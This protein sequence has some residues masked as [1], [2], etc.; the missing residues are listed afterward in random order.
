MPSFGPT[1]S[2]N[3]SPTVWCSGWTA[4]STRNSC[5]AP[6]RDRMTRRSSGRRGCGP[7]W[8]RARPARRRAQPGDRA[9]DVRRRS[10]RRTMP[11][12]TAATK[13]PLPSPAAVPACIIRRMAAIRHARTPVLDIAYEEAGPPDGPPV[14]LLHGFPY[15][16]RAYD[17]VVPILAAAGR[18]CVVPYLR[19]YGPTRFLSADTPRSGEQAALGQD[20]LDLLDALAHPARGA[21]RLRLGRARGLRGGRPLAGAL[22]RPGHLH[23]LQHPGHRR[24]RAAARR[25]AGAPA[26]VPVLLPHRARPGRAGGGPARHRPAAVAA[27]VAE[28]GLRRGD[29]R[30]KRAGLRQPG[31]RGGGDPVLPPPLR[32]RAR[33]PGAGGDRGAAGGAAAHRRADHRPARSRRRRRAAGVVGAARAVLLRAL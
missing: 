3:I 9:S 21:R 23:R 32:L 27:V 24:V 6:S 17:A 8:A 1:A 30:R 29:L 12:A 28:L 31:F 19:G 4:I 18:R 22:R 14:V 7:V 20:L 25:R 10:M 2:R 5:R 26:L 33:R 15:A 13:L 16:P 11:S